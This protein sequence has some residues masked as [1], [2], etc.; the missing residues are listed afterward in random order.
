[1]SLPLTTSIAER[2]RPDETV[3]LAGV[4]EDAWQAGNR[5][6]AVVE[7]DEL[8]G[9]A[10]DVRADVAIVVAARSDHEAGIARLRDVH[11]RRVLLAPDGDSGWTASA[12]L[13][14][15]FI[16]LR[17]EGETLWLYDPEASNPP[18]EW[19][20]PRHWA[21]PENFDKFRW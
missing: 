6:V 10:T 15:G 4:A 1:M 12:L 3:L 11:C 20:N 21:N 13:S 7:L 19:N 2:L 5:V 9:L 8:A 18:R 16:E 14:L 17:A